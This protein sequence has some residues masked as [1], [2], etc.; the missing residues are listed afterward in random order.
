M[1]SLAYAD[2]LCLIGTTKDGIN[3]MLGTTANFL[4]WT[5]LQLNPS[6]RASLS[7]INDRKKKYVEPFQPDIGEGR[8]I[9][10]L[11]WEDRYKY[12]GVSLGRERKGNLDAL[13]KQMSDMAG[14]ITSSGLTDWQKIDAMNTFVITKASYHFDTAIIDQTW[15]TKVD[16]QLRKMIKKA[17]H[18][19]NRTTTPFFYTAK[20]SGG[21]GLTS[22]EDTLHT[23]R[24]SRLLSCLSSTDKRLNDITWSQLT[25]VVKRRRRLNDVTTADIADFLNHPPLPQ[26]K[27]RDVRSLWN[28]ARK[29][30]KHISCSVMLDGAEVSVSH[31]D[32]TTS[33]RQKKPVRKL[34][35]EAR[36]KRHLASLLEAQDQGRTF[37]LV[38]KNPCSN[39]WITAGAF[40]SFSDYRFAIRARLN[41]L[42]T[43]TVAKRT[44]HPEIDTTYP[45][46]HQAPETLGHILNACMPNAGLMRERH[47]AI[48]KR[49]VKAVP[50]EA[51]DKFVEQKIRD[52]PGDLRPDLVTLN[53]EKKVATI[54]DVTIPYEGEVNSFNAAR[55]EKLRKYTPLKE[56]LSDKGFTVTLHAFIVGALGVWD[57]TSDEALQA[58]GIQSIIL[59]AAIG[60]FPNV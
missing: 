46:C 27:T 9:P 42:P 34:L 44:G 56:W 58:L 28:T 7:M 4:K 31:D 41:L 59:Q 12:L 23:T 5:G 49:L 24:V 35:K 30:L 39:H 14:K 17:L 33:A 21:L 1:S 51:G 25:S 50:R 54:V 3:H 15:A 57:S 29:S 11:K 53:H 45:K 18:L 22:M 8:T 19:P 32:T 2:N 60:Q 6:K 55:V 37:H 40:T 10:A 20:S 47:N 43:K 16:A 13:A 52:A 26:E 38:S 36:D 48:L